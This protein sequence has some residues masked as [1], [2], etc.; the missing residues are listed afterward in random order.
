M[1]RKI[2]SALLVMSMTASLVA[3]GNSGSGSSDPADESVSVSSSASSESDASASASSE[4]EAEA[5]ESEMPEGYDETSTELYNEALGDFNDALATA[6]EAE[7]VDERYA[8]MAVAEG[9]LMESAMM[10]P[11]TSRGGMYAMYRM[12]PRTKDYT[13]WGSDNDRYHQ[14]VVTTDFIKAE[15]YN[16]MRAKWDELKGTG[17]YESWVKEYLA[18]KGY[19]LKDSFSMPY[20]SDP[21]TW[22]GLATSRA[23]DNDAIINTYDGL[24]E[25]DVEGTLQPALAE[26]YEVSDDGLTYTFHLRKD[27][28]WTDSQG[29]EVDTVKA[30]DFVAGMQHMCDAQGGL[31]YLVQGVIKNVSQYISGEVTDFDEVGV[32]AVDDYTV[33]YTLEEPCS[34]FM[35]M[36]GYTIFMPMSRSYYQSQGGK[37]GAEYDS[38]AADYQYG[39]DSNS[40]AYC[41]PYLVTN[42]TAKNTIVFKLSDSYWNKDNVNI[43]TLTWLFNDQS[44]VTKM[45]TDAKAGT[46][47]YVNLN[48]ST[49]ETA[50][51][52]GLYDQYAVVSD[53]DATSFMAFYNINRTATANANDGTTAKSTKSDEEIQRTNKALQNVHFR[54]AISFAADRGAYNAQKVGEDLKYTSLRNTFTPGYFVSLSK[55]TTIQINGTDT[56]FPAGTYYGEIVQKQIDADGVK[57]KVWDAEN[58]TSDGFDGWYNPEN[59]VEE[60]NT[61]IEEL[62]EEGITI[63][64]SN[65]I[66]MEYPYPSAV[67]VY[68]NKANSYKK[69]V[70]AALGGKVVINLVDAVDL[71]GWY[72][73]GYYANYGYEANYDVYDV[74]GWGPDFGDPCSY[75]DTMLPDYEGYM[76]KCFGIF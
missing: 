64:E 58:K 46:V 74:S 41:G 65:P 66:Q 31:E 17:T 34:Y 11:L 18:G 8:L 50:K 30:D 49:M 27:V 23:A 76:T 72:Y 29:R 16:E 33:E 62:A 60:L 38:S 2:V 52:E 7:T 67:E 13:L 25:Y 71:D 47:D 20:A 70:E 9:K 21:V 5:E 44:D 61:A 28:K 75:L 22:D 48:T 14:Y 54:R 35:T 1:K 6:K 24:M 12:A 26:S 73:A 68:T 19:T 10:Y 63:D 36:L 59:A 37:F 4:S 32:K 57:I 42:A 53:T 40:I 15:D 45:Y 3:C 55:D 51:S 56:T 69:S 39:K 43:K